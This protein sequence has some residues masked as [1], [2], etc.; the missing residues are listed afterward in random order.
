MG[1]IPGREGDEVGAAVETS[2][3]F[4]ERLQG[5]LK[6]SDANIIRCDVSGCLPTAA[7]Y[8]LAQAL[9]STPARPVLMVTHD[10]RSAQKLLQ[11]LEFF[12]KGNA[13]I[14]LS[15]LPPSDVAPYVPSSP[16]LS[17]GSKRLECL[18]YLASVAQRPL[19]H[20]VLIASVQALM[21][22]VIEPEALLQGVLRISK[23]DSFER[24]LLI[25][26]L[27][28]IGYAKT[29]VVEDA[30]MFALRGAIVDIFPPL[31][32]HPLRLEFFGDDLESIRFF[33]AENQ[34]TLPEAQYAAQDDILILPVREIFQN[35]IMIR[36]GQNE[37]KNR[38]DDFGI[39]KAERER[40]T[41]LV[42]QRLYFPGIEHYL[43]L[44]RPKMVAIA[45]YFPAESALQVVFDTAS[46]RREFDRFQQ[47]IERCFEEARDEFH[48]TAVI[49][50]GERFL[51]D[52]G[53]EP[54]KGAVWLGVPPRPWQSLCFEN[55]DIK[56]SHEAADTLSLKVAS[57]GHEKLRKSME[58]ARNG[59]GEPLRPLLECLQDFCERGYQTAVVCGRRTQARRLLEMLTQHERSVVMVEDPAELFGPG[60]Q[61]LRDNPPEKTLIVLGEISSGFLLPQ[62]E[63]A[64]IS[65]EDIFGPRTR[66]LAKREDGRSTTGSGATSMISAF[67][68]LAPGDYIVHL[69]FGIGRYLGLTHMQ[70]GGVSNDFLL[71]EYRAGD[72]LYLPVHRLSRIQKYVGG[73]VESIVVD[74]L[75]NT[76][77]WTQT[78]ERI[79]RNIKEVA[80]DLLELYAARQMLKGHAFKKPDDYYHEFEAEFP[81]EE[82]PDQIRSIDEVL[83]DM[84]SEKPMDRL[85]C[86]DVGYG[87]TEV[88]IRA[89]FLAATEGYQSAVL[90]PTTVLAY[91]HY[92]TLTKRFEGYPVR[93]GMLSRFASKKE[94]RETLEGVAQGTIDIVVGT[95]RLLSTDV[96]F[97]RLGLMVVDEEQRF[98]VKHKE[99]IKLL[100]KNIHVLTL[101]ATPIPRTLNMS[102]I[103]IR[104]LSVINTPPM[105]RVSIKT[106][107]SEFDDRTIRE[108]VLHEIGR[109]GQVY[110]VHN[111]VHNIEEMHVYLKNL[112]PEARIA[113][114]HGQ[115]SEIALEEVMVKFVHHEFDVLLCTAII[116][117]GLDIPLV[118]TIMINRAD[119]FGLS[120]LYQ[121]RG[122]V[123]RSNRRAYAYL[124]IPG[125]FLISEDAQK[126]LEILQKFTELGSGFRIASYDLEIRGAGNLLG[127]DQ[128]GHIK[129]VGLEMYA[130]L[131]NKA[132]REL[133]GELVQ[134]EIDPEIDLQ[135]PAFLPATYLVD[136]H[137]RLGIYKRLTMLGSE[138]E[139]EE[140]ELEL[141]DRFG[142]LPREAKNLLKVV[143]IKVLAKQAGITKLTFGGSSTTMTFDESTTVAIE[144]VLH[145]VN[146]HKGWRLL[147][148]N[149]LVVASSQSKDGTIPIDREAR[150]L[151]DT[152][153]LLER[154]LKR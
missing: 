68:E 136:E 62:R 58:A 77:G 46:V 120:Q 81:Y 114:G 109:G 18:Y 104:D 64:V 3:S 90:A 135:I 69:D 29:N 43:P 149:R 146:T 126:R 88:A 1:T 84:T 41:T 99:R 115:M 5:F 103:G 25:E 50:P 67:S 28:E 6:R 94:I 108:A 121:L 128:S 59:V 122:R 117:S 110:F 47:E 53:D 139:I 39:A 86:G 23:G 51:L 142:A 154:L 113:V 116:E 45:D 125:Q 34:R 70:L 111:R 150:V 95:H 57:H 129:A 44:F 65:E 138:E 22:K 76:D 152:R 37:M 85:I 66:R 83:S 63:L 80:K 144:H 119:Q 75:G 102:M 14:R 24:E 72:K 147:P 4:F 87:K 21:E 12:A 105:D 137:L 148:D 143:G 82:T 9:S 118:N 13:A 19:E 2:P 32:K 60:A 123:G 100:R 93:V 133:K 31:S 145:L 17:I 79:R 54:K 153:K 27:V 91:Q 56:R 132:V 16:N 107:V 127:G 89:M 40:L 106:F 8:L 15:Y 71:L 92:Q 7:A 52:E 26:H 48:P 96:S 151:E 98:G 35:D 20:L 42:S 78:K 10:D 74:R 61:V 11:D 33:S 49:K 30:G 134:D 55:L 36:R 130:S 131:M 140:M 101:S 73:E 141:H 124:L 112:L 38:M 97:K